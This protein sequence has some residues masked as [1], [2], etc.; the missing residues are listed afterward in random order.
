MN[1][2]AY[3]NY[4]HRILYQFHNGLYQIPVLIYPYIE[5]Q[6]LDTI[7]WAPKQHKEHIDS[8][9]PSIE[10][11][12]FIGLINKAR[13]NIHNP[14]RVVIDTSSTQHTKQERMGFSS[15]SSSG[16]GRR[17]VFTRGLKNVQ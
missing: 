16:S 12:S 17:F 5:I 6:L 9:Y 14:N 3:Y 7:T 2:S 11:T 4:G 1:N 13:P 10:D 15:A 8:V